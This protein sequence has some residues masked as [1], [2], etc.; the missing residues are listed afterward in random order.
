MK[1]IDSKVWVMSTMSDVY[2]ID[3]AAIQGIREEK[4]ILK[5]KVPWPSLGFAIRATCDT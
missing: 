5:K 2:H 3:M 4:K 1:E